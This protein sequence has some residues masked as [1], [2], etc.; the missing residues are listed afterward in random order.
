MSEYVNDVLNEK[1]SDNLDNGDSKT[2]VH[3]GTLNLIPM[4]M[5][6][7]DEVRE[8]ARVGG[9]KSGESRRARK[10]GREIAQQLLA[11]EMSDDQ[12]DDVLADTKSILGDDKSVYAVMQAKMVQCANMGNVKAATF[13]RDTAGDKPDDKIQLE[14]DSITDGDREL[15][16]NVASAL[17]EMGIDVAKQSEDEE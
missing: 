11:M 17:L 8:I 2:V 3:Q 14:T 12:I 10:T 5:R 13:V 15:L 1:E 6:T 9:I 16:Q 7:K 4:S